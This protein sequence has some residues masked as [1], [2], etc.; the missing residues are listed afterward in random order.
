MS[1]FHVAI[2]D[3]VS[4]SKTV[5]ESDVY[6]FAGITGDFANVHVNDQYMKGSAYGQR[7]AHGVLLMGYMSTTSS[8]MI[9]KSGSES[10]DETAVSLGYDRVRFIAP[11][12]IGDTV[13]VTYQIKDTDTDRRRSRSDVTAINQHGDTVAVAEHIMKWVKDA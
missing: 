6:G 9:D 10:S 1:D 12:F 5:G 7:I 4:F 13:T 2:G 8:M 11:V 3:S